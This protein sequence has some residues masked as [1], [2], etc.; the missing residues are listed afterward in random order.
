MI[1]KIISLISLINVTLCW[2]TFQYFSKKNPSDYLALHSQNLTLSG[3]IHSEETKFLVHGFGD[4][5]RITRLLKIK[6]QLIS[7]F[8]Y[9]VILVDWEEGAAAPNYFAASENVQVIGQKIADF[10][11]E[12]NIDASKVHC[13]GH[14]LG[15]HACGFAGKSKK[16]RRITGLDPAGPFFKGKNSTE[17]LDKSDADFVD[18]IH[19]DGLY[20]IQDAIGHQDFYPNGGG[21]QFG[22]NPLDYIIGKRYAEAKE[23]I[24]VRFFPRLDPIDLVACSHMRVPLYYAES[25]NSNCGFRSTPCDN[26]GMCACDSTLGCAPMGHYASRNYPNGK[27]YLYT[28]LAEPYCLQYPY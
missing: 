15:A 10:I 2:P 3:F 20:G 17:R 11:R 16:L 4:N 19:T 9:N 7:R 13:I 21:F 24:S 6:D 18:N 22:C 8:N 1:L 26:Y 25:V 23:T 12:S 14:S 27:Y 28:N 5:G